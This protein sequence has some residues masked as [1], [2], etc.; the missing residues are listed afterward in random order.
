MGDVEVAYS[1]SSIDPTNESVN[2]SQ[3]SSA[4]FIIQR[5]STSN[6]ERFGGLVLLDC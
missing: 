5:W 3:P 6:K 4:T 1:S 2:N